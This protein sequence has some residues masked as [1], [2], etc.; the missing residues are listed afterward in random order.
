MTDSSP[1]AT[2]PILGMLLTGGASSRFGSPKAMVTIKGETLAS[3][4]GRI[5][6]RVCRFSMEVGPGVSGL[7]WVVN[8][9]SRLGPFQAL[10]TG[11]K[12]SQESCQV[13]FV[14]A[15]AVD[16]PL[17]DEQILARLAYWDSSSSV[18]PVLEGQPQYLLSRIE[19]ND[20]EQL[21]FFAQQGGTSFKAGFARLSSVLYPDA[22]TLLSD[23]QCT[24]ADTPAFRPCPVDRQDLR[25]MRD[26]D[27]PE[28][29]RSLLDLGWLERPV[30]K[31][32]DPAR[33]PGTFTSI[34]DP[35]EKRPEGET[36]V[37]SNG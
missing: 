7:T 10:A 34:S 12:A 15:L 3:R 18:V 21:C 8:D 37:T 4:L 16:L 17:L 30:R 2:P 5:L 35:L 14:V 36:R 6:S 13:A 19:A 22:S 28:E 20:M 27:T 9:K 33:R 26:F 24:Q 25:V 29:L 32:Y 31:L 1:A 23:H 11:W